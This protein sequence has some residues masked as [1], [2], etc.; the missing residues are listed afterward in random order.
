MT[1]L[2]CTSTVLKNKQYGY[3]FRLVGIVEVTES[4]NFLHENAAMFQ[5]KFFTPTRQKCYKY[6]NSM[7]LLQAEA[8]CIELSTCGEATNKLWGHF[9]MAESLAL[10]LEKYCIKEHLLILSD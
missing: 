5:R 10:L 4:C 9:I 2:A 3:N 7:K 6:M 8:E 1:L